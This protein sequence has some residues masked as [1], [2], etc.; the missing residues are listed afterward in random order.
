MEGKFRIISIENTATKQLMLLINIFFS[1]RNNYFYLIYSSAFT[2]TVPQVLKII[3]FLFELSIPL[4][5][6]K[7][8]QF[9]K[10]EVRELNVCM[11]AQIKCF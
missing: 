11:P 3:V 9:F 7:R 5:F 6:K 8:V 1:S 2:C 4:M 10:R